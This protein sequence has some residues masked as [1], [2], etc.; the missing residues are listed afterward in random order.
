M[1]KMIL[2]ITADDDYFHK[3]IA[4]LT[5]NR[6]RTF[7]ARTTTEALTTFSKR[8]FCL[9]VLKV[10]F[11]ENDNI[12][13]VEDLHRIKQSP[14]LIVHSEQYAPQ[15]GL[16]LQAGASAFVTE[17]ESLKYGTA[18]IDA[19]IRLQEN[20]SRDGHDRV[21]AFG[22]TLIIDPA[23]HSVRA[24]GQFLNLTN[25]E[26]RLL[27]FM[28][29]HERQVL[30][31]RQIYEN[32]WEDGSYFRGDDAVKS[33]IKVLRKKLLSADLDCIHNVHGVGYRF[34]VKS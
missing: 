9:V 1:N 22:P 15:R 10:P 14:I 11:E 13:L 21:I 23:Y 4:V 26:F 24:N 12:T 5:H 2:I 17:T 33:C 16:L 3:L 32:V 8:D 27:Y 29:G 31:R 6:I 34:V 18:Q 20:R 7:G 19:L 30:S 25:R 28:A